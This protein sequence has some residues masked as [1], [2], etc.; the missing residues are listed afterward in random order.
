MLKRASWFWRS[1][2]GFSLVDQLATLAVIATVAAIAVP[3]LSNSIENQRLGMDI[4]NVEREMQVARLTAVSTN[5]PIRV[6]FNCPVAG[7]Y[8]R[9]ELIGSVNNP[10]TG[11]DATGQAARRC[12]YTYYP[13][14]A[15]DNDPLTRPN[16]D[17]PIQTL[18]SKVTFTSQQPLEFW[19]NG[20]V[21]V[22]PSIVS[23]L[24]WPQIGSS[25]V[26][27][28]LSKGSTTKLIS[29][30]SLGKMQFQ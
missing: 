22:A 26:N 20:T 18:N 6:L 2:D 3:A 11:D 4:R 12:N 7:Q 23:A 14:P 8:R 28:V 27:I 17:G 29:V 9:V 25:P 1:A 13:F 15:A 16:N 30:N 19:P 24:P 10:N 21:H 5:R